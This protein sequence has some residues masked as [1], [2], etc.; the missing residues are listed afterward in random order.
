MHPW[1]TGGRAAHSAA[2][3]VVSA[4]TQMV[5]WS[6]GNAP[7]PGECRGPLWVSHPICSIGRTRAPNTS[8]KA[9]CR[10]VALSRAYDRA[11]WR[12]TGL[13]ASPPSAKASNRPRAPGGGRREAGLLAVGIVHDSAWRTLRVTGLIGLQDYWP[14][15]NEMSEWTRTLGYAGSRH[16]PDVRRPAC[17]GERSLSRDVPYACRAAVSC[18]LRS[19][20]WVPMRS[21]C[22]PSTSSASG[23]ISPSS[24]S[25]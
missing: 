23:N 25:M 11:T 19:S 15:L 22:S 14:S 20:I 1:T 7:M 17:R 4:R 8:I 12:I 21:S 10:A 2:A 24:S 3:R 18:C 13:P 16:R 5:L 6:P 9:P